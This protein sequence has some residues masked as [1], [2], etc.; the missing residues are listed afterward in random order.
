MTHVQMHNVHHMFGLPV[1]CVHSLHV[2]PCDACLLCSLQFT[3][4]QYE[5]RFHAHAAVEMVARVKAGMLCVV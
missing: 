4:D 3:D 5:V 2:R 1:F